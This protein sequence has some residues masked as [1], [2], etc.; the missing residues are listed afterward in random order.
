MTKKKRRGRPRQAICQ[1]GHRMAE[2]RRRSG[3]SGTICY[4]CRRLR[5]AKYQKELR[6]ARAFMRRQRAM[7]ST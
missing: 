1:R 4:A 3:N 7:A 2:T 6:E 5:D